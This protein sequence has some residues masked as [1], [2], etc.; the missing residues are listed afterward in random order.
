MTGWT[1]DE[2]TV[3]ADASSLRLSPSWPG[4]PAT[5]SHRRLVCSE[6]TQAAE[7]S[8]IHR[9]AMGIAVSRLPKESCCSPA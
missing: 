7:L 3:L 8:S 9:A 6:T 5:R 4:N 2:L 1:P